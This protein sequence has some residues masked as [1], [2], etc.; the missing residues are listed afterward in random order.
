MVRHASNAMGRVI[1]EYK[2]QARYINLEDVKR[3]KRYN[4]EEERCLRF[5]FF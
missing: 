4:A 2:T 5:G 1:H 3:T